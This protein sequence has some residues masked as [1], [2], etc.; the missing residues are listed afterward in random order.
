MLHPNTIFTAVTLVL[1][2]LAAVMHVPILPAPL[3]L[4]L[5][6]VQGG[7]VD[8]VG[9]GRKWGRDRVADETLGF[10]GTMIELRI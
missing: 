7:V 8:Q 5:L 1:D 3:V 9:D 2:S 4:Q 10:M 6:V